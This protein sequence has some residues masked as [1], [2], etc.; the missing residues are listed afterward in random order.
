[1]HKIIFLCGCFELFDSAIRAGEYECEVRGR[2]EGQGRHLGRPLFDLVW[3]ALSD[4]AGKRTDG[5]SSQSVPMES[6]IN[7]IKPNMFHLQWTTQTPHMDAARLHISHLAKGRGARQ[8]SHKIVRRAL[9][10]K[11]FGCPN[12]CVD[13]DP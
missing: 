2:R 7:A 3:P 13:F 10:V 1:M 4:L 11:C 12:S 8:G 6:S 9:S 5:T